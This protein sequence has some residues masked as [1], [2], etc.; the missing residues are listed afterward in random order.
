MKMRLPIL[1]D[2]NE[3]ESKKD[4][5]EI[6][7]SFIWIALSRLFFYATDDNHNEDYLESFFSLA[8]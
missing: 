1:V 3:L 2:D 8:I 4:Y 5:L 6:R 7:L